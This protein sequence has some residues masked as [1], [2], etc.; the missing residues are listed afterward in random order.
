MSEG[1]NSIF[2]GPQDGITVMED[3]TVYGYSG[4]KSDAGGGGSFN[5]TVFEFTTGKDPM[6]IDLNYT[7]ANGTAED[8]YIRLKLNG[9]IIFQ[10]AYSSHEVLNGNGN[11]PVT[12][13]LPPLSNFQ[14]LWGIDTVTRDLFGVITGKVLK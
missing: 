11:L 13:T 10:A 8:I 12:L 1:S 3:G 9:S 5:T 7:V 4:A 14:M 6:L 2:T